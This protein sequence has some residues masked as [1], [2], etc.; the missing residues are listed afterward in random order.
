M[1]NCRLKDITSNKVYKI[2]DNEI[3]AGTSWNLN[4]LDL[5]WSVDKHI[6]KATTTTKLPFS[7][8]SGQL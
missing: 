6:S 8:I 3:I 2:K 5:S 4:L 1:F 7:I